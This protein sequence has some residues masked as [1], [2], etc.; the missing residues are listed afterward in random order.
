MAHVERKSRYLLAGK[1]EDGTAT[2][3]NDVSLHLFRRIPD[4]YRKTLTLDNRSE[5]SRFSELEGK[6]LLRVYFAKP[7]ASWERGTNENMNGLLRRF[8]PKGTD[9]LMVTD[10]EL[11]KAV[12][13][14]NH[15]PRKC[16]SYRTSFEVSNSITGGALGS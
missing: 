3:F 13:I 16:L 15:R 6:L 11:A 8:F 9:F 10:S 2:S 14:L 4:N 1:A 5:N 7:Y 12:R